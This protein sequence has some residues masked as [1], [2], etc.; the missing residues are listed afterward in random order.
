MKSS[1]FDDEVS[2]ADVYNLVGRTDLGQDQFLNVA[3]KW[4]HEGKVWQTMGE[5]EL[6][7][8]N[9]RSPILAAM[10]LERAIS[11]GY[12]T[13]EGYSFLG[14]AYITIGQNE[15]AKEALTE[16]L[17]INPDRQDA[18]ALLNRISKAT[19]Q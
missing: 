9:P 5:W 1:D 10:Y 12:K 2:S 18:K 19:T 15:K 7:V 17:K 14:G 6:G 4:P 11:E 13:A 8:V 3:L 16:A